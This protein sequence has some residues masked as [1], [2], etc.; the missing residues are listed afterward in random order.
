M[1]ATNYQ[2]FPAF[3]PDQERGTN[4]GTLGFVQNL[5]S[6]LVPRRYDTKYYSSP[7]EPSINDGEVGIVSSSSTSPAN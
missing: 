2:T 6:R 4:T 5:Q 7:E 3:S 1:F